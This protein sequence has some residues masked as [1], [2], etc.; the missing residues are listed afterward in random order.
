MTGPEHFQ[1]AERLLEVGTNMTGKT[2]EIQAVLASAQ[3]HARLA[4]VA[5]D[6]EVAINSA[7]VQ[8]AWGRVIA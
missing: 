6:A 3:V 1:A 4:Q 2:D 8:P 7:T 5:L